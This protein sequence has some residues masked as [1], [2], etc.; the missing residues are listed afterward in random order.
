MLSIDLGYEEEKTKIIVNRYMENDDIKIEDVEKAL[1]KPIYWRI[2]NNYYTI[3][4]AINKGQPVS[5]INNDSNIAKSY[6]ELATDISDNI[7][8]Q[9]VIKKINR[10]PLAVLENLI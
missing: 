6:R 4:S 10:N 3:M 8:R 9:S 2:P 5:S 1:D 7:Y